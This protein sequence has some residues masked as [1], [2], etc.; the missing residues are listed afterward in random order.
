MMRVLPQRHEEGSVV[1]VVVVVVAVTVYLARRLPRKGGEVQT[2]ESGLRC[3]VM[4]EGQTA[5]R[6]KVKA[7]TREMGMS[8]LQQMSFFQ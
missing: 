8:Y 2:A 5:A 1:V 4:A 7:A 3:V 6:E